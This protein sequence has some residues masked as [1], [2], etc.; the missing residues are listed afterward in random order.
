MSYYFLDAYGSVQS[1]ESSVVVG[2]AQRQVVAIGSVLQAI[3]VVSTG[4]SSISGTIGA[5]VIGLTPVSVSNFPTNPSISGQVG[6]S[7]IGTVPVTQAGAWSASLVG[8]IPTSVVAFQGGAW[9]ASLVG[10]IPGSVVAFVSGLQGA[11]I[12][13]EVGASLIG[14]SPVSVSNFPATQ[15]VS[16]SVVAFGF[17]TNQN[18]SGSVVAFISGTVPV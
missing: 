16:D 8:T 3:P 12:S 15:N 14:L 1:A 17:P 7:V 2:S 4:N 11:S 9:S 6:S 13:G 5:S 10:T 18:V